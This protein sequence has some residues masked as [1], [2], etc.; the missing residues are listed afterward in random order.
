[1]QEAGQWAAWGKSVREVWDRGEARARTEAEATRRHIFGDRRPEGAGPAGPMLEIAWFGPEYEGLR[2]RIVDARRVLGFRDMPSA[3]LMRSMVQDVFGVRACA[4]GQDW[5]PWGP[6]VELGAE[7]R[8]LLP[9][10]VAGPDTTPGDIR[11]Q[12]AALGK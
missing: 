6:D 7:V 9:K 11:R 12:L 8:D 2:R 1:M 10:L 4:S 3:V 5:C